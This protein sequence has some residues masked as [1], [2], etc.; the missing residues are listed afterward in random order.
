MSNEYVNVDE[1]VARIGGNMALYKKLLGRFVDGNHYEALE[2]AFQNGDV[3]GA[4]HQAHSLKGVSANLSLSKIWAITVDLEQ[5]LKDGADCSS[6][7]GELK[8]AY[9][10]TLDK[11][12]GIMG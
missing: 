12:T 1:A 9:T 6:C 7:M 11:I 2:S 4:A 10:L 3:E 5:L 8:E